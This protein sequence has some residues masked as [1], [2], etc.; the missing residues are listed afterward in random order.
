M[1]PQNWESCSCKYYNLATFLINN[2][3]DVGKLK[4]NINFL[5]VIDN[6]KIKKL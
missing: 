4:E 5:K 3:I 2:G 1:N 6:L